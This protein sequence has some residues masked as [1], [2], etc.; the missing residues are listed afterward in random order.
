MLI[1]NRALGQELRA[2][3]K[4]RTQ[5]DPGVGAATGQWEQR[6]GV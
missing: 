3:T 5:E 4:G 2:S 6:E 1:Q